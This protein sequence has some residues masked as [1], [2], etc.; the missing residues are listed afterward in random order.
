MQFQVPQ[1]IEVEDKIIGPLTL[2]QFLYIAAPVGFTFLLKFFLSLPFMILLGGPTVLF[3]FALAFYKPG[4][5]PF[6]V[7]IK[8]F[9][10]FLSKPRLYMWQHPRTKEITLEKELIPQTKRLKEQKWKLNIFSAKG[11]SASG[12]KK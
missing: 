5:R 8:S 4:G 6:I 3:G 12:G 9:F 7:M 11:G 2:K 1:F 10:N